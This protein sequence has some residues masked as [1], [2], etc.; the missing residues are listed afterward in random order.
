MYLFEIVSD[1]HLS[2]EQ[3]TAYKDSFMAVFSKSLADSDVHVRVAALQATISFLTSIDDTDTVM[4]YQG[5]VPAI[6]G[7][8]VE[9]LK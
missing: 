1:C 7:V 4:Q 8:V 3:I 9:A 2:Q 5:I 6:L